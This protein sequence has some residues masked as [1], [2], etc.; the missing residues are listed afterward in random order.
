MRDPNVIVRPFP[1]A[2]FITWTT[3]GTWLSGD[4]RGWRKRGSREMEP[5][6]AAAFRRANDAMTSD[7][8]VLSDLQRKMIERVIDDHCR[9]RSWELHARNART[10]HIHVVVTAATRGGTVRSQ[11]KAW[12]NRRLSEHAGLTGVGKEGLKKWFTEKG[13]VEWIESTEDLENVVLY[14]KDFQ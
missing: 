3:Y 13:D 12:S 5:P 9:F 1:L 2:Y 10:N 14:V 4:S 7:V 6:D 8:V 11:L